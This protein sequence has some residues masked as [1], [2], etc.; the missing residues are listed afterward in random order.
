MLVYCVSVLSIDGYSAEKTPA[1]PN[2]TPTLVKLHTITPSSTIHEYDVSNFR[3]VDS[4]RSSMSHTNFSLSA[5]GLT[6]S[7]VRSAKAKYLCCMQ[8]RPHILIYM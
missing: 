1:D 3:D 4:F 8:I 2:R 7:K 5:T 6:Y